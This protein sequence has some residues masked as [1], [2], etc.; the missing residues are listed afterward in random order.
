MVNYRACFA[1]MEL[2]VTDLVVALS[3]NPEMFFA[4]LFHSLPSGHDFTGG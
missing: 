2:G 1:T 4:V 3:H